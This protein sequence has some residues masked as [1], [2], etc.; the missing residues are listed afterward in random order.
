HQFCA[1]VLQVIQLDLLADG[2]YVLRHGIEGY[3]TPT[4]AHTLCSDK[5]E[6]SGVGADIEEHHSGTER[7]HQRLLYGQFV[8]TDPVAVNVSMVA[9]PREP[10]RMTSRNLDDRPLF[11]GPGESPQQSASNRDPSHPPDQLGVVQ[12]DCLS[13]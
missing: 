2:I 4:Q 5:R 10:G 1:T 9:L 3:D 7:P 11:E 12:S 13:T 6:E 8:L